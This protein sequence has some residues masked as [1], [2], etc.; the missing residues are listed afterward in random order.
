MTYTLSGRLTC[1]KR[2]YES[3]WGRRGGGE[4]DTLAV[5]L[6]DDDRGKSQLICAK[7]KRGRKHM[8]GKTGKRM[9]TKQAD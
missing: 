3:C 7:K 4:W 2:V 8:V 9:R 1:L 6:E 5:R